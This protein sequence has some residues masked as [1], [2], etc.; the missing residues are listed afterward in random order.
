MQG[1]LFVIESGS[2][3]AGKE[4]QSNLLYERLKKEGYK[5]MKITY[6]NY[7]SDSSALVKMYLNGEFG[8]TAEDVDAYIAS[9]FFAG[10]RYAS[11]KKEWQEFYNSGGIIIADRYVPSNMI[12]QASKFCSDESREEFLE[13][14]DGYEYGLYGLPRPDKVIFLDVPIDVSLK[15][16]KDRENKTKDILDRDIHE[17]DIDYLKSTYFNSKF[18]AEKYKWDIINCSIEGNL[19]SKEDINNMIWKV[20]KNEI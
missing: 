9:T 14:V 7:Q 19:K 1:K 2:D 20:I 13:W 17:Q 3:G 18:V 4:T 6:P 8:T 10:D 12:Y 5:A 15:L 11:Y 16:I